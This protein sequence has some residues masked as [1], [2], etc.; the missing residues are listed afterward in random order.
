M[1]Y[2]GIPSCVYTVPAAS[3]VG[4]TEA[5]AREQGLR[6]EAKVNDLTSWRAGR[7]YAERV[8]WSKV[9]VETGTRR[10]LGVH[11]IGHDA[12]E[13]VQLFG[14]AMRNGLG[15]DAL[16]DMVFAYPTFMADAKFLF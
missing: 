14:F 2:V 9:M 8:A 12:E 1:N 15:A 5:T 7:T 13:V 4:L 6:F 11:M 3:S 10:F 16:D